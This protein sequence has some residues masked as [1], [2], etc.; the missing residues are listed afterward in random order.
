MVPRA[1]RE[2]RL[3]PRFHVIALADATDLLRSNWQRQGRLPGHFTD[4]IQGGANRPLTDD[5]SFQLEFPREV[6]D[7]NPY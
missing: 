4:F 6:T 3:E 1:N 5:S 2:K 7:R